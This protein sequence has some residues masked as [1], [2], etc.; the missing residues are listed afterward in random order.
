MR[1]SSEMRSLILPG[2]LAVMALLTPLA[3]AAQT[4]AP[5]VTFSKD[6]APV[7]QAKCQVCHR[8][9]GGAPFSMMTYAEV[10]PWARAIKQRVEQRTMPPWHVDAR[11]G[12]ANKFHNDPSLS[13][14]QIAMIGQWVS[15]G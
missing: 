14:E 8:P 5:S 12:T 10:R 15:A 7:L 6:V 2:A 4:P 3:V 1:R 9:N 13:D 11:V